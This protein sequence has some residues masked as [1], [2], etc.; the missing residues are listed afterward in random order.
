MQ[1][2]QRIQSTVSALIS[3]ALLLFP[4][5]GFAQGSLTP[6]G[7]PGPTMKS[8]SQIEPRT[9]IASLPFTIASPGSYYLTGNLTGLAGTNGIT[10]TSGD[11]TL[12]LNGFALLGVSN[13]ATGIQVAGAANPC[14]NVAIRNGTVRGWGGSGVAAYYAVNA[15]VEHL[16][17]SGNQGDGIN[18]GTGGLV[19]DCVV[20]SCGGG[21]DVSASTVRDC[22]VS[23]CTNYGISVAGGSVSGCTVVNSI[24]SGISVGGSSPPGALIMDNTCYGNNTANSSDNAGIYVFS[25]GNRIEGNHVS[26]NYNAGIYINSAYQNNVVIR[27]T[28]IST[29]NGSNFAPLSLPG[30]QVMGPIISTSGFIT[31][32]NPWANFSF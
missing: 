27:N 32:A 2:L 8:L 9:P 23:Y 30:S 12:D 6:P 22:T 16:T 15:I 21:I 7:P 24:W 28:V 18:T 31:N 1:R 29:I 17:A 14:T 20:S 10:V 11:V 26:W 25:S 5:S 4:R 19:R 3:C 13:S